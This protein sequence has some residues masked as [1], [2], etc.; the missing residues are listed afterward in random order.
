[1]N[2]WFRPRMSYIDTFDHQYVGSFAG[3]PI[4]YSR[5][6]VEG[7]GGADFS[8]GPDNLVLGGGGG[9]HPALVFHRS[10][11]LAMHFV[12]HAVD[13]HDK[14]ARSVN[15]MFGDF[16]I[17]DYLEVPFAELFEF[18]GWSVMHY[19]DFYERCSSVAVPRPF[20]VDDY[21]SFED[22][23]AICFGELVWFSFPDRIENLKSVRTMHPNLRPIAN[24]V[25]IPPPG[26]P[27]LYG[28]KLNE[29]RVVWG[30][31]YFTQTT[32]GLKE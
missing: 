20:G 1:M 28:R 15:N 26:Y 22:W 25:T 30:D 9:E 4:Y 24:N 2:Y 3:L 8:C 32:Q 10:D 23:L 17:W 11:C 19:H 5:L 16:P 6:P 7:T 18:A 29:D 13:K 27:M 31:H 12:I 14:D 21:L